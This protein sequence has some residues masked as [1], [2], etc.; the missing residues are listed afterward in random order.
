MVFT[1]KE[2]LLFFVVCVAGYFCLPHR[3]RWPLLLGASYIFYAAGEA[4]YLLLI[5]AVSLTA[6][7]AALLLAWSR[8][9]RQRR[10]ILGV[11]LLALLA[12]LFT[13]KYLA[14]FLNSLGGVVAPTAGR[15]ETLHL[16]LLLP[17]GISFF[18]FQAIG[19]VIDVHKGAIGAERHPGLFGLYIAFF[20]QLIAGPIER[21]KRLLPQFRTVARFDPEAAV[22]GGRLIGD[23]P[24]RPVE[25][26]AASPPR[27]RARV[28]SYADPR[29]V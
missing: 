26:T 6:Y 16:D 24:H 20:P 10:I 22:E 12:P 25:A 5:I 28:S 17:L 23:D 11:A 7:G 1:T 9:Q 8:N 19:Y 2:F 18:T 14:F 3:F 29:R 13:Y 4:Q 27:P 15:W 21:A